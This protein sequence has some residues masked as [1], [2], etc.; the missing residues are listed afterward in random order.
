MDFNAKMFD[1]TFTSMQDLFSNAVNAHSSEFR[2]SLE[3]QEHR[4]Y[5]WKAFM[6]MYK[7][8][9]DLADTIDEEF[10]AADVV[11]VDDDEDDGDYDEDDEDISDDEDDAE[12]DASDVP[13]DSETAADPAMPVE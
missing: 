10:A 12:D 9:R 1:F 4:A 6:T 3:L 5:M 13:P 8:A 11:T 2:S 7:H